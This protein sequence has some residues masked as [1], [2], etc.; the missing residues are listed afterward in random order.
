MGGEKGER[1]EVRQAGGCCVFLN[2]PS[3]QVCAV[4]RCT[5]CTGMRDGGRACGCAARVELWEEPAAQ[6]GSP[7]ATVGGARAGGGG[8][9]SHVCAHSCARLEHTSLHRQAVSPAGKLF[10]DERGLRTEPCVPPV[11]L[12]KV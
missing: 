10:P 6:G 8:G 5:G 3:G 9:F 4:G 7:A 1:W 11:R 2:V 12:L